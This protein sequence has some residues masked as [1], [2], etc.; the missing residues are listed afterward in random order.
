M[1]W[2]MN[3]WGMNINI[4]KP[5]AC[6]IISQQ[7]VTDAETQ[8]ASWLK[9]QSGLS[10]QHYTLLLIS[11]DGISWWLQARHKYHQPMRP[12]STNYLWFAS[13]SLVQT[14]GY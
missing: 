14:I 9:I 7:A 3:I 2:L 13:L 1:Q 6:C 8:P 12:W 10:Q 11:F 4:S 5:Y